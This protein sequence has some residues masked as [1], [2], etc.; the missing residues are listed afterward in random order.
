MTVKELHREAMRLNDL[1]LLAKQSEPEKVLHYYKLAFEKEKQAAYFYI[2]QSNEEPS[3]SILLRSAANLALLS[4][5]FQEAQVLVSEGLAGQPPT[6]IATELKN[7]LEQIPQKLSIV[8]NKNG[9]APKRKTKT[10]VKTLRQIKT[11][12]KLSEI[13]KVWQEA[14]RVRGKNPN[15]YRKD[16]FG[17]VVYYHSYGKDSP[18]GWEIDYSSRPKSIKTNSKL[19]KCK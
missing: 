14:K 1:A 15:L 8:Q 10:K 13:D 3:R 9:K 5:Q 6:Q 12:R 17:N 11:T 19:I 18:M 2:Q 7:I 16:K 4:N